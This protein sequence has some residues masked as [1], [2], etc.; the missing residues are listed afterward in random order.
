M[1]V[2]VGNQILTYQVIIL[3]TAI[4]Y[5]LNQSGYMTKKPHSK[6]TIYLADDD[7]DDRD[8]LKEAFQQITDK[9]HLHVFSN[10]KELIEFLST[11][12]EHEIPC[13]IVLDYN[14]PQLNGKEV[15]KYLQN[16]ARY[17]NIPKVIYSTSNYWKEKSEFLALGANE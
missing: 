12:P 10:G 9:H 17:R 7:V 2:P 5:M 14:M 1:I 6:P 3:G 13:L 4:A 8:L 16:I 11:R 15:L